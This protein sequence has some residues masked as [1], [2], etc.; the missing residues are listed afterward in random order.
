M[1]VRVVSYNLLVQI[2]AKSDYYVHTPPEYLQLDYR[3]NLIQ[4]Q[5][6]QEMVHHENTI[7]CLQEL[8]LTFLPRIELFFR[9]RNYSFFHDLY[10]SQTSD[11]MGVGM[12][13]PLSMQLNSISFVK[14]GDYL[15]SLNKPYEKTASLFSWVESLWKFVLAQYK[16]PVADPWE[17]AILRSNTLIC[18]QVVVDGKSLC[19][20][21]YHMPCL[22]MLPD[23]MIIHAAAVKELMFQLAAGQSFILAGDFN[24]KPT[25]VVYRSVTEKGCINGLLPISN[26]H[27]ISFRPDA[28]KVLKSAYREK[29]GFEPVYTNSVDTVRSSMFRAT[30][31]YIFFAGQLTVEDVLELPDQPTSRSYPD[32]THPSDHLMIAATFRLS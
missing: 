13:I 25:D 2:F 31:D 3:W 8:C 5:L 17:R 10:G 28:E 22:Y 24:F 18:L 30:L 32:E 21:T 29:N 16:T 1:T 20:G 6:D 23:V 19:V 27:E 15:G 7:I 12:A 4:S 11:Y 9:Q 14:V 26:T